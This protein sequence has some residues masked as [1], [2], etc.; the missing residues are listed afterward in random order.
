[1]LTLWSFLASIICSTL[2]FSRVRLV[3]PT[4]YSLAACVSR[5]WTSLVTLVMFEMVGT[6]WDTLIEDLEPT[7]ERDFLETRYSVR[8]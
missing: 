5:T 8:G 3:L 7:F 2:W 6:S 4:S 1:M